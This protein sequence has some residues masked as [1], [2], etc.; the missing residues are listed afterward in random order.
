MRERVFLFLRILFGVFLG[1]ILFLLLF[2]SGEDY[3]FK[4]SF[5]FSNVAIV[6]IF[7]CI[8]FMGTLIY[9]SCVKCKDF[10]AQ[11]RETFNSRINQA[12]KKN[13]FVKI[14][15]EFVRK[16]YDM[17]RFVLCFCIFMFFLQIFVCYNIYFSSGW[18]VANVLGAANCMVNGDAEGLELYETYFSRYP[19]NLA[20]TYIYALILRVAK[21]FVPEFAVFSLI[22]L[23]CVIN[24]MTILLVYKTTKFF[25]SKRIAFFA[26]N[27]VV[28]LVGLSPWVV[29][30]YTDSLSLFV[31]ILS[32]YLY[33]RR[34]NNESNNS[35]FIYRLAAVA[36]ATFGYCIKPQCAIVLIAIVLIES[37]YMYK[38]LSEKNIKKMVSIGVVVVCTLMCTRGTIAL[39]NKVTNFDLDNNKKFGIIHFLNMSVN[40]KTQGG[41]CQEDVEVSSGCNN[42]KER[43]RV[44]LNSFNNRIK[45]MGFVGIIN[46]LK[47]KSL[48]TYND[49]SFAWGA[50]GEFYINISNYN[51]KISKTLKGLC[52]DTSCNYK[53]LSSVQQFVWIVVLILA[54]LSC[55]VE[56]NFKRRKGLAILWL[57]ML[58]LIIYEIFFEARARYLYIYVPLLCVIASVGTGVLCSFIK[59][60]CKRIL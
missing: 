48:M 47:K 6:M 26:T 25:G 31:P 52:Y 19:N 56:K 17:D 20:I 33:G 23:N 38:E 16:F 39:G 12:V 5:V 29:I 14:C 3:L 42:V 22:V 28:I 18:D 43:N 2:F 15:Y 50:E 44:N 40:E 35:R 21:I 51:T 41:Y 37:V 55:F 13:K 57:S 60:K 24:S 36:I 27:L 9:I 49:G 34:F 30:C 7:L 10:I 59:E 4:K 45:K 11:K 1:G 46:H 53:Y 54:F 58:G 8:I 32:F